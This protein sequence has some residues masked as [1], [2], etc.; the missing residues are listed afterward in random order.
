MKY[1]ITLMA[2]AIF[3]MLILAGC[4]EQAATR[5]PASRESTIATCNPRQPS[6]ADRYSLLDWVQLGFGGQ[7]ICG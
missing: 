1:W 4:A 5:E 7:G 3:S 2:M 6:M